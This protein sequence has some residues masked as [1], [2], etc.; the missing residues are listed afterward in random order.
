MMNDMELSRLNVSSTQY[1]STEKEKARQ[2]AEQGVH[3]RMK[4]MKDKGGRKK[5]R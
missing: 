5:A 3:G 2:E 1:G 4:G